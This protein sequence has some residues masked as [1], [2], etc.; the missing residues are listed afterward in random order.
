M[1]RLT[2]G[3]LIT[4]GA[5]T[6]TAAPVAA[7]A[8]TAHTKPC[9]AVVHDH[10]AKT[11]SG[12]G[13]PAEWA[14]LSLARTTT[15][16]CTGPGTY[17]VTLVDHG[18]LRTKVGGGTPNGTGGAITNR[19]PGAVVGLYRLTVT[20]TLAVPAHRDTSLSSTAYV[21]S[22]FASGAEV[23]G[24]AYGW[25]YRTVCGEHWLDSSAN[26]DGAGAAAGNI[27]GKTCRPHG[28]P[29]GT[30]TPTPTDTGTPSPTP[31]ETTPGE[32][33]VPTPVDSD[34]PVTG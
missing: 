20:G 32:A 29:S 25:R 22:L 8:S 4:A 18:T 19:V 13:T 2:L 33:P 23:K 34:L 28:H 26:D 27:T 10:I 21:T 1:K 15:V 17:A 12:H 6:A 30:P 7:Y 11:D 16:H 31:T 24:G 14:D 5:L 9:G 3:I